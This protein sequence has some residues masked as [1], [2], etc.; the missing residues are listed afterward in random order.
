MENTMKKAVQKKKK[1]NDSIWTSYKLRMEFTTKVCGSIPADENVLRK[2]LESRQP[3]VKP[4]GGRSID[5][6]NEEVLKSL[7]EEN[8]RG[9]LDTYA[10]LVFQRNNGVLVQRA[11]TIRAHIKDCARIISRH[12]IGK[13]K[14]ESSFATKVINCVYYD[15]SAGNYWL[16]IKR[17]D[18]STIEKEDGSMTRFVHTQGPRGPIDAIKYIQYVL[19][20]S[21][22]EFNLDVLKS[23]VGDVVK[24]KDLNTLFQYGMKHGY[25]GERGNGEGRYMFTLERTE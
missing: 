8:D 7:A 2:W 20:P 18:G 23:S 1:T 12:H 15:E 10:M 11:A 6:I 22:I 5:E 13:I 16:P 19:P 24:E 9:D 17:L 3:R 25:G 4:P 14:G 21:Y